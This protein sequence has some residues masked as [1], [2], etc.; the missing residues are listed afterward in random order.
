MPYWDELVAFAKE[1]AMVVPEQR[2]VGWD[3]ALSVDG[4]VI[5][6]GNT[7]PGLQVLAG[8]GVGV[9]SILERITR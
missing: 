9:R 3:L 5:I 1:I 6:E 7:R 4:W 2:I 8:D